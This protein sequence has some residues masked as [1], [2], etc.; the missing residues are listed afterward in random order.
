MTKWRLAPAE[1][2][3]VVLSVARRWLVCAARLQA[4]SGSPADSKRRAPSFFF[5]WRATPSSDSSNPRLASET[6]LELDDDNSIQ[7]DLSD[8]LDTRG[9]TFQMA[10]GRGARTAGPIRSLLATFVLEELLALARTCNSL[11]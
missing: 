4:R 8:R 3:R 10:A 11:G 1:F 6:K 9:R 5:F 7:I 2:A